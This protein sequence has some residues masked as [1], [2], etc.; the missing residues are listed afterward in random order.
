MKH[1]LLAAAALA[2]TFAAP[3]YAQTH[4]HHQ[5]GQSAAPAAAGSST[6]D[7]QAANEKMHKDMG[8]AYT[9]DVD[10]DFIRGMIPHHQGAIDMAKIV[11]KHSK[12]RE[13]RKLAT[14]IISAQE[15]EID[16]MQAWLKKRG[17]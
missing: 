11:L 6:A 13:V 14:G 16:W 3:A 17:K 10:V 2:F 8:I 15:K 5:H 9:G 4:Q 7:F 12:S 1:S